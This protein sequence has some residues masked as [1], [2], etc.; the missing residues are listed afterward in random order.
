[1]A[2]YRLQWITQRNFKALAEDPLLSR[3]KDRTPTEIAKIVVAEHLDGPDV[4]LRVL[5]LFVAL[6]RIRRENAASLGVLASAFFGVPPYDSEVSSFLQQKMQ[7]FCLDI[8][9][10]LLCVALSVAGMETLPEQFLV[11]ALRAAPIQLVCCKP[12]V[13]FPQ[14]FLGMTADE[15]DEDAARSV[16]YRCTKCMIGNAARLQCPSALQALLRLCCDL[17]KHAT[18]PRGTCAW[19]NLKE[20]R[21]RAGD[22][23]LTTRSNRHTPP[24]SIATLIYIEADKGRNA[25]ADQRHAFFGGWE[26]KTS[27]VRGEVTER[28]LIFDTWKESRGLFGPA[29]TADAMR[30]FLVTTFPSRY[31]LARVSFVDLFR[32]P[33][34]VRLLE[35]CLGRGLVSGTLAVTCPDEVKSGMSLETTREIFSGPL[36]SLMEGKRDPRF[37]SG[38]GAIPWDALW[39]FILTEGVATSPQIQTMENVHY[40]LENVTFPLHLL[41]HPG[42]LEF[43]ASAYAA[44][45]REGADAFVYA[46]YWHAS[47]ALARNQ[48][49]FEQDSRE[50]P[51]SYAG[52][53]EHVRRN[54][55]SREYV[56]QHSTQSQKYLAIVVDLIARGAVRLPKDAARL[57]AVIPERRLCE[58]I[59]K[60]IQMGEQRHV[61]TSALW[62]SSN[63]ILS[64][65]P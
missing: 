10:G 26:K 51:E 64:P 14:A 50:L 49:L 56:A 30:A 25:V 61:R 42:D 65:L 24:D 47:H 8:W 2:R 9:N 46:L 59:Q 20:A 17:G 6:Y 57:Q 52:Q 32:S 13:L 16:A 7:V 53:H 23:P 21:I 40:I 54:H 34:R 18:E 29:K 37:G 27:G 36:S 41:P 35:M 5:D 1:M 63:N 45:E 62:A 48:S 39:K 60:T 22:L 19:V 43:V 11:N 12:P 55:A 58:L 44:E 3:L 15:A 31:P 4:A 33:G 38:W 28:E